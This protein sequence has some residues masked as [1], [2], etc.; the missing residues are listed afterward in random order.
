MKKVS[1]I[2]IQEV[3]CS[4]LTFYRERERDRE[5]THVHTY[6]DVYMCKPSSLVSLYDM[7]MKSYELYVLTSF[8]LDSPL[9]MSFF[10]NKN[11]TLVFSR[12]SSFSGLVNQNPHIICGSHTQFILNLK[13]YRIDRL[14]IL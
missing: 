2:R 5:I 11:L 14:I 9:S 1:R 7:I 6:Y 3:S 4:C 13:D 10:F 12:I 8:R